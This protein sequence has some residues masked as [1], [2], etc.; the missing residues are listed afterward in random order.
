M[1][2]VYVILSFHAHEPLWDFPGQLQAL[3]DREVIRRGV[4]AENYLRKRRE[5]GR[6]I[7][8]EMMRMA[9][10]MRIPLCLEASN[11]LLFQIEQIM[12]ETFTKLKRGFKDR[13]LH[14]ILGHAHHTHVSLLGG[15]EIYDELRLNAEYLFEHMKIDP[16]SVLGA[17]PTEDSID[18][19]KLQAYRRFGVKYLIFP[20]LHPDKCRYRLHGYG[21]EPAS[22]NAA[23]GR[24]NIIPKTYI[25]LPF[26]IGEGLIGLPR[27]FPVSQYIWRPI[28]R[29][30]P[31]P[32]RPQGYLL[33]DY[34]V[35]PEEY[36]GEGRV[37][38][39]ISFAEGVAEYTGV[40]RS[41]LDKAPEDG[42]LL[43]IQDLELMDFGDEA[44]K[45]MEAAW[46]AV[47]AENNWEIIFTTPQD[48]LETKG[49]LNPP[50]ALPVLE[51]DQIS[52][53][54]EI[55]P[56]LRTDGHYP[57]LTAGKIKGVDVIRD[58]L[59]NWPFAFWEPGRYF[60]LLTN[61]LLGRLGFDL[62]LPVSASELVKQEY[63]PSR[64]GRELRMRLL[65]R[66][67]KRGCNWGWRPDEARQKRPVAALYLLCQEFAA[68]EKAA[69]GPAGRYSLNSEDW[70]E[71][72]SG[73]KEVNNLFLTYRQEY[74]EA[75]L[76]NLGWMNEDQEKRLGK[77]AEFKD[78]ADQAVD[79]LAGRVDGEGEADPGEIALILKEYCRSLFLGTELLQEIWA[80][81]PDAGQLVTQMYLHLYQEVPPRF[82]RYLQEAYGENKPEER[83]GLRREPAMV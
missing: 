15:E 43:Y 76:T 20:H 3:A 38:F 48:Y 13:V 63:E 4:T 41:E 61:Y 55:R 32:L 1:K 34:P 25:Y 47:R 68:A 69:A 5:A 75:G 39:P 65:G 10:K 40:L 36:R 42:L 8:G 21:A 7:Y 26:A 2:R 19:H 22:P 74:L 78:E 67:M 70:R 9:E 66:L 45:V 83:V 44:L 27:N 35:F 50:A 73:L 18:S 71:I 29:M 17:F 46:S 54:P 49:Y 24:E 82:L 62:N 60:T 57:P 80:H 23:S 37:N 31:A 59:R 6:D 58:Y 30:R 16:P 28:T 11:E 64:L 51:F 56:V 81:V 72:L 53:A 77:V 14:P 12:P 52:W 33:G 79:H